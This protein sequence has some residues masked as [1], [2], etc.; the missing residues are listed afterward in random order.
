MLPQ[1][2]ASLPWT[3]ISVFSLLTFERESKLQIYIDKYASS[4]KVSYSLAEVLAIIIHNIISRRMYEETNI[5]IISCSRELG[6]A[7]G[8]KTFHLLELKKAVLSKTIQVSN[9][10][11][12]T[13]HLPEEEIK[14]T[15][16]EFLKRASEFDKHQHKNHDGWCILKPSFLHLLK[17]L[18]NFPG[19]GL[20]PLRDVK[21]FL[22][23]YISLRGSKVNDQENSMIVNIKN[24]PLGKIFGVNK[25]HRIQT[26]KFISANIRLVN[27]RDSS[28]QTIQVEM[29]GG[30][31]SVE[32]GV[33]PQVIGQEYW[34]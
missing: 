1:G 12:D 2:G 14:P 21:K 18:P 33:E 5:P 25:F 20:L 8:V 26:L 11:P 22:D 17:K 16:H 34:G 9:G 3:N 10:K 30:Q 23:Q 7:I 19:Q 28:T 31:E 15:V 29:D 4:T 6:D 13:I 24:D 32:P 27:I